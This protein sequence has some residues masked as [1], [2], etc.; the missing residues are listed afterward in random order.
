MMWQSSVHRNMMIEYSNNCDSNFLRFVNMLINDA[1]FL[2]DE[3]LEGLKRIR[4][5]EEIINNPARWRKLTT[6]EQRDLRSHLQQDERVV[7]ASFQ[8]ASVTV[9]MFSYMTDVIKEPFLCPQLGNRLA[10]MLNYNMAQLCGS[11]F[12]HLRVRNPGLYN[13]RP[14]L[15]LD[16][17]TDIYL[18]LDSVKFANAIASD[19]RSYSNQLFEDVIDRILKH[20]V[21]PISQVEQFRLLA[22]K[23]HLMWNQKQKVEESWGEIPE[24]FCDPV[25]GTLMKDPVFLPSGHVMDREII[26]RHLLNTP[27]D[28]FSRLPL[29]EAM[30]TPGK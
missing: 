7:R 2:L 20:C 27:T 1:T 18:H 24:N 21:K 23:A 26:L 16:Q 4:E 30:L 14:R 10:A 3:S 29:N 25:M 6:E 8:L 15:L 9:D 13:W 12:K 11:E 19:E 17:L 22:E 28:P 5:T